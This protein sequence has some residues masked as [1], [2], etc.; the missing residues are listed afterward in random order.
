MWFDVK[1]GAHR[2]WLAIF[3]DRIRWHRQAELDVALP[4]ALKGALRVL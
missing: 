3:A 1:E 4:D 2:V